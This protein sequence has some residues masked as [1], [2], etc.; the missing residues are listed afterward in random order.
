MERVCAVVVAVCNSDV[1]CWERD[2]VGVGLVL[3]LRRG[4]EGA[5][6][7]AGHGRADREP[8]LVLG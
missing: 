5:G 1:V 7:A 8:V 4:R 3:E 6:E 2:D